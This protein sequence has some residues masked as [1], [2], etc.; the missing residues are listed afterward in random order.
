MDVGVSTSKIRKKVDIHAGQGTIFEVIK[1]IEMEKAAMSGASDLPGRLNT[2]QTIRELISQALKKSPL[3]RYEVAAE[4]SRLLGREIT[5]AMIDSWSA[6]SKGRNRLPVAYLSAFT[7]ATGDRE[8]LRHV[9]DMSGG[10]YIENEDALRLELGR[11]EEEKKK[12]RE[13]ERFIKDYLK[14]MHRVSDGE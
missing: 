8:L 6:E 12:L 1:K 5:K 10:V 4:M 11:V 14:T 3:N 7:T 13:K 2:D 9:C